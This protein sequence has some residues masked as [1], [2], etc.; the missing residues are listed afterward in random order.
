MYIS[1]HWD[2]EVQNDRQS[3]A[4]VYQ[5]IIRINVY[6]IDQYSRNK[7]IQ[8]AKDK[9]KMRSHADAWAL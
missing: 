1:Y 3:N 2:Q 9:F 7:K 5:N 4:K 8:Q 6:E